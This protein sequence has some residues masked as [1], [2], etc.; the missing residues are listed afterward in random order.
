MSKILKI[1]ENLCEL[2]QKIE[3][4]SLVAR[5]ILDS[6]KE[7]HN[8]PIIENGIDYL[9]VSEA[10][11]NKI[12]YLNCDRMSSIN[13]SDFWISGKRYHILPGKVV[14]KLFTKD[15]LTNG[16]I[17]PKDIEIFSN[18]Y[19]SC[20]VENKVRFLVVKGDDIKYYYH[21][22]KYSKNINGD[23]CGSLGASCMKHD[24]C[25]EYFPIY[26]DN[27]EV[28][29]LCLLDKETNSLIG[30]ALLWDIEAEE[31]H[32]GKQPIKMMDRIYT[33]ND[34]FYSSIFKNWAKKNGYIHK[35]EQN[36]SNSVWFEKDGKKIDLY[37][38]INLNT[39][40]KYFPYLD[41]FK[42][43]DVNNSTL[44]NYP[45]DGVFKLK[46]MN[47]TEGYLNKGEDYCLDEI[48]RIVYHRGDT[49]QL[50]YLNNIRVFTGSTYHSYV[51]D[52]Y[53]LK[54]H[55]IYN[56][57]LDDY[58]FNEEYDKF[59]DKEKIEYVLEERKKRIEEI[60]N[61][62]EILKTLRSE[63]S[64]SPRLEDELYSDLES[65]DELGIEDNNALN[66]AANRY[67][68]EYIRQE[69]SNPYAD[70]LADAGGDIEGNE[71]PTPSLQQ[72]QSIGRARRAT[73]S[74]SRRRSTRITSPGVS[75][76]EPNT[77]YIAPS[78]EEY[79]NESI[80]QTNTN[81]SVVDI[82][83]IMGDW[84]RG[85]N[86]YTGNGRIYPNVTQHIQ[87]LARQISQQY[88]TNSD[89]GNSSEI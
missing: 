22:E 83:A 25:Q 82:N 32:T 46:I 30:R 6:A 9:S 8:L 44:Y 26:I 18:V 16:I 42:F 21:H 33:T 61:K 60:N 55:A 29:L 4:S 66:R 39:N 48:S 69:I 41:T 13:E 1:S 24:R 65:E 3:S 15:I 86:T 58:I 38:S 79:D 34:E 57:D 78:N 72:T 37:L 68:E 73:P 49:V 88:R 19:R 45:V 7:G 75:T 67:R 64:S 11:S 12:S 35:Y 80:N 20:Q 47:S 87:E 14:S 17:S 40:Y 71:E 23:L 84:I 50:P 81:S 89:D 70:Y 85:Y 77:N 51:Q 56:V 63:T 5:C 28:S 53:I 31:L 62:R 43:I 76:T 36:H 74:P 54:S 52:I 10:D 2:L 27:K 59:N